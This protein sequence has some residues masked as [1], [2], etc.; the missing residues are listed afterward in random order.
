MSNEQDRQYHSD[1]ARA[2]R[3]CAYRSDM[4]RAADAHMRLSVL[5]VQRLQELYRQDAELRDH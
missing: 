3:D 2:E 1:R 5:H 4:S